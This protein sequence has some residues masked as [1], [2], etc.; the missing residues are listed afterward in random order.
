MIDRRHFLAGA[1]AF[2]GAGLVMPSPA[3]AAVTVGAAAPPFSLASSHG[4]Q[5]S[6]AE[7]RGKL[8]VLEWSNHDCPYV[9]KHYETKNMQAIQKEATGQ[10]AV[11]LTIIS[12]APGT[13][14]Q[15][16]KSVV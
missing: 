7:H 2:A 1:A 12:S 10:G 14:G 11:W 16:R 3:R 6:L 13:Q 5:V 8:V 15:D 4:P 9:R